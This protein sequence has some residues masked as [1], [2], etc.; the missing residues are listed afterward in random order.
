MASKQ[1]FYQRLLL[2]SP[3]AR[4]KH[5]T[6]YIWTQADPVLDAGEPGLITDKNQIVVGD[7]VKNFSQLERFTSGLG[8][9]EDIADLITS[10][11]EDADDVQTSGA[12]AGLSNLYASI[13]GY[14]DSSAPDIWFMGVGSS[15]A[16]GPNGGLDPVNSISAYFHTEVGGYLN[17]LGNLS[18]QHQNGSTGGSTLTDGYTTGYPAVKAATGAVPKV[19]TIG[20]GMNDG[21]PGQYHSGQTFPFVYTR[22]KQLIEQAR[23]DGADPIVFT[24]PHPHSTRTPWTSAVSS[25]TYPSTTPLPALT[26]DASVV[27]IPAPTTGNLI[28][29]SYRHLRVNDAIRRAANELGALVIDIETLWFD[30]IDEYGE[31][32]LFDVGQYNHP[33]LFAYQQSYHKGIDQFVRSLSRPIIQASVPKAT[34]SDVYPVGY[35]APAK[36]RP[37]NATAISNSTTLVSDSQLFYD[38]PAIASATIW[39]IQGTVNYSSPGPADIKF[40]WLS[41][42]P[43]TFPLGTSRWSVK[44]VGLGD[45]ATSG[46]TATS[47]TS[48]TPLAVTLTP[49]LNSGDFSGRSALMTSTISVGGNGADASVDFVA[50]VRVPAGGAK[51]LTLQYAQVVANAG[52]TTVYELS[53]MTPRR[54]A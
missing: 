34:G 33:N 18:T 31:D 23:L 8:S 25:P 3:T 32:A 42:D 7:G 9:S 45:I 30:A 16:L 22:M 51:R 27:E 15:V 41:S 21:M 47:A 12:I 49:N 48:E 40:G 28:P 43:A 39:I 26:V 53:H 38:F 13:A 1:K 44:G 52:N 50:T 17:R 20:F 19:L 11:I 24:T 6:E 36:Y 14:N 5:G 29:V 46:T 4:F 54:I 35:V 2:G 10:E 37:N